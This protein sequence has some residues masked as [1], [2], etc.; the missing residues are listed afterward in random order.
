MNL[1]IRL[2]PVC[3]LA[4]IY[5]LDLVHSQSLV[6]TYPRASSHGPKSSR[7]RDS[8]RQFLKQQ[9]LRE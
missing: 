5:D 3:V 9:T 4:D 2:S 1:I 8:K 7:L 6:S